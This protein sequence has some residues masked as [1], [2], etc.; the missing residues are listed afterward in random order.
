MYVQIIAFMEDLN[1]SARNIFHMF[2]SLQQNNM[3]LIYV[4]M[5]KVANEMTD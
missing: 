2:S 5:Y 4:C 1:K 3:L